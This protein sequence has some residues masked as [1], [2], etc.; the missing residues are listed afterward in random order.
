MEVEVS[1]CSVMEGLRPG[2]VMGEVQCEWMSLLPD[3]ATYLTSPQ[4]HPIPSLSPSLSSTDCS[5]P[6]ELFPEIGER[7]EDGDVKD[8]KIRRGSTERRGIVSVDWNG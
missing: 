4:P 2:Q 1:V 7:G 8:N 3:P 5:V 6:I